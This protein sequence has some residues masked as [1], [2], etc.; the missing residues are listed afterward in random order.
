MFLP[1]RAMLDKVSGLFAM[2]AST[3][4]N[5]RTS[6]GLMETYTITIT[7][8]AIT[9]VTDVDIPLVNW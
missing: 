9:A 4:V 1:D 7:T 2:V 8:R 6:A 5:G 3:I